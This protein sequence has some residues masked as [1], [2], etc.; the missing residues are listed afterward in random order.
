VSVSRTVRCRSGQRAGRAG[1]RWL[2]WEVSAV[3]PTV[4]SGSSPTL[5]I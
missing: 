5:S 2:L 3:E 4:L 1:G